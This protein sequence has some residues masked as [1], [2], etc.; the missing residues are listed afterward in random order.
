[1]ALDTNCDIPDITIWTQTWAWCNSTLWTGI[2]YNVDQNCYNYVWW[3]TAWCNRPSNEKEN[4][5]N[6]TYWVNNIWW[7]LYTW[8]NSSSACPTWWHVPSDTEWT[9]LENYLIA[10]K[11]DTNIWWAGHTLQNT[12]N[13][14]VN[15][16]KLPLAGYRNSGGITFYYRGRN[17]NL[18]SSTPSS[19]DAYYRNL[20]WYGSTVDR[21]LSSQA[22][23]FSVRCLK[24]L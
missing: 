15:A 20:Y 17:T 23:G 12:T 19:G 7:K 24:D 22:Y 14:M 4:V 6:P 2:E 10:N 5:Y 3:F 21:N 13:N 11:W 16:L 18:W 9:T 8:A 1:M